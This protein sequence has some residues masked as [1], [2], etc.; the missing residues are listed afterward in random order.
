MFQQVQG[1][2]IISSL[3]ALSLA[4]S[5]CAGRYKKTGLFRPVSSRSRI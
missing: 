5:R 2:D 3:D 1:L 4:S